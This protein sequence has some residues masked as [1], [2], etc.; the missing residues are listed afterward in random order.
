MMWLSLKAFVA[1]VLLLGSIAWRG[2]PRSFANGIEAWYAASGV[3]RELARATSARIAFALRQSVAS[4][5]IAVLVLDCAHYACPAT[6]VRATPCL[7]KR[8]PVHIMVGIIWIGVLLDALRWRDSWQTP[9]VC[10][11]QEQH[12]SVLSGLGA[13]GGAD[14]NLI[15]FRCSR[16]HQHVCAFRL[17]CELREVPACG[18]WW[19]PSIPNFNYNPLSCS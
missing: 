18:C 3:Q 5:I 11:W 12:H 14:C 15:L 2:G 6:L 19:L 13:L 9:Q 1:F 7:S 4:C 16:H 10:S 8:L 17:T